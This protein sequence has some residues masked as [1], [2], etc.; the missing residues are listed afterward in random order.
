MRSA[1]RVVAAGL[2]LE[3]Q[4][5]LLRVNGVAGGA[6]AIGR[7]TRIGGSQLTAVNFRFDRGA[8]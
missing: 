5:C 4:L 3:R 6:N 1:E 2:D 7:R 8:R